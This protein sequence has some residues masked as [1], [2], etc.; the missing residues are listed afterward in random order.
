MT[1][2]TLVT[3]KEA[4]INEGEARSKRIDLVGSSMFSK[5]CN[6]FS[7]TLML[8]LATWASP[9]DMPLCTGGVETL[10]RPNLSCADRL[11]NILD[12]TSKE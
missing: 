11:I 10:R 5:A 2:P 12:S 9:A 3:R 7:S 8:I 1:I 4:S 6:L